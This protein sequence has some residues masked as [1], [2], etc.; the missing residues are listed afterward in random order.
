MQGG[1]LA[2]WLPAQW[3]RRGWSARLLWPLSLVVLT[4]VRARQA[5]YRCGFWRV[6]RLAVPVVVV[7]NVVVG[8]SG[9]TPLVAALVA[10]VQAQGWRP[11]IVSRGYG[12]A[13]TGCVEVLP[14]SS[15]QWVGDEPLWLRRQTQVPVFVGRTRAQAARA[16]LAAHP[17]VN[18][19][20]ADDGL[21][22]MALG[23]DVEIVVLDERGQGNGWL[24]PAGPLREPWPR[25]AD[26]LIRTD[27]VP[28]PG[29]F[30]AQRRLADWAYS[31]DGGALSLDSLRGLKLVAVAGIARP[32]RFFAMLRAR[33]LVLAHTLALP[34][35]HNFQA[36]PV[37][38]WPGATLLCT[39]KDA[40][41][42]WHT[43]PQALAVPLVLTP[44]AGFFQALDE[45]LSRHGRQTA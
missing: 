16:L 6:E 28:A 21:Q 33:G 26:L 5:L 40:P 10:H 30:A 42:L 41:K 20:L 31:A 15:P 24:L 11:G 43:H 45:L 27:G 35:H 32:E 22:H 4:L 23:R 2:R 37:P 7:G 36:Q 29:Q 25:H 3:Q 44:E 1:A 14:D 13:Y 17:A 38:T 39:E 18:L 12:G 9:K 19:L 34:D 8:G